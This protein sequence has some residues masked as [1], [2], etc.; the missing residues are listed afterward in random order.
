MSLVAR[1]LEERG[2]PTLCVASALDIIR[3]GK[4]PRAVFIDYPLGHTM[5]KPFDKKDQTQIL[6]KALRAFE[7]ASEPAELIDLQLSWADDESWKEQ[8][9]NAHDGDQRSPRD[10]TPRYQYD[11]DRL[12]AEANN[13]V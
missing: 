1:Y 9:M 12:L 2:I 4:P 10:E 8:A 3:A 11:E 7:K 13:S 6:L 5:G